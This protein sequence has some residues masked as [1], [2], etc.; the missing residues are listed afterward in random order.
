[1][2]G[3]ICDNRWRRRLTRAGRYCGVELKGVSRSG[4]LS[5]LIVL[6]LIGMT[7]SVCAQRN[8]PGKNASEPADDLQRMPSDRRIIQQLQ[9]LSRLA[10]AGDVAKIRDTLQ[11]LQAA[12]PSLMVADGSKTFRPLHRDLIERIQAFPPTLQLEL[13][14]HPGSTPGGLQIAWRDGG[15]PGLISFLHRCSG[16]TES[17]KAHLY[18]AAIHRDRGHGQAT[19][20]WLQPVLH[21]GAPADLRQIAVAMRDEVHAGIVKRSGAT[22]N[23]GSD[24]E[25][26]PGTADPSED[27]VTDPLNPETPDADANKVQA[28]NSEL[29]TESPETI[30]APDTAGADHT[31]VASFIFP[32]S[33]AWQRT[34]YLNST[35]RRVS[36]ELVRLLAKEGAE[37]AIAWIASEPEVDA[38]AVYVRS[39]GG[40]LALDRT[41]GQVLWTRLLD[42]SLAVRTADPVRRFPEGIDDSQLNLAQLLS[43]R[44]VV[45]LHR[46]EVTTGMTS[47]T[48]RLFVLCDTGE[49]A[50]TAADFNQPFGML[51]RRGDVVSRSLRELVAIEKST[52][53]RLWS[54]GGAPLEERFGNQL[55]RAWFAGPP[56]VSGGLLF[57][58]VERDDAHWLVC[59]RSETGEVVWKSMLAYPES[60]IFQ[61]PNR[62]LTASRPL[63]ADGMVWT[64]TNDGLLVAV[65]ALTHSVVWIRRMSRREAGVSPMRNFRNIPMPVEVQPFRDTW[66]PEAMRLISDSL[67]IEGTDSHQLQMIHPLTG[68]VRRSISPDTATVVLAADD[69]S[70]VVAGPGKIQRLRLEG[71][72]AVWAASLVATDVVPTGPGTR[73]NDHLWIPLSDGSI[74]I[75]RYSDGQLTDRIPA[76]R[77]A[78]SAGGLKSLNGD[79]VSYGPDHIS[80][81][82]QSEKA[83]SRQPDPL[84]QARLL[85][86]SGQLAAAEKV[87]NESSHNADQ[88]DSEQKLLFKLA[89]ARTL[90]DPTHSDEHLERAA[91]YAVTPQDHAI[92]HFLTVE[93]N[94]KITPDVVADFLKGS[95]AL[96]SSELPERE[97]L[98]QQLQRPMDD[99]AAAGDPAGGQSRFTTTR[100]LRKYLLQF[101]E[102]HLAD[103]DSSAA[104]PWLS[105]LEKIS[106]EDL[107]LMRLDASPLQNELLRRAEDSIKEGRLTECNWHLLMQARRCEDLIRSRTSEPSELSQTSGDFMQRLTS[108]V[109][110]FR[111]QLAAAVARKD[112]PL[113]PHRAASDLLDVVRA[114][115]LPSATEQAS[116]TPHELLT[117]KWSAWTDQTYSV[118]PVNPV[119]TNAIPQPNET[120]LL[121][122][123]RED[124]FLSAWL[125]ST[126]REPSVLALHSLIRPDEPL[127]TIEGGMFDAI[128]NSSSGSVMRLGSVVLVHNS[129]GLSAVSLVDQRV[130]WNRRI[131]NQSHRGLWPMIPAMRMFSSFSTAIEP[132]QHV[133]GRE[134]RICGGNDRWICLQSPSRI[135]MIDLLTGQNL[136]SLQIPAGP[137]HVFATESCVFLSQFWP[138]AS[139]N[140]SRSVTCLNRYDGTAQ[141]S[142]IPL[143]QLEQTICATGDELVTWGEASLGVSPGSLNW[144]NSV[145]GEVRRTLELNDMINCQF[146]D[147]RTLVSVTNKGTFEI[148]DLLTSEKQ[149]F[150]FDAE[151]NDGAETA[152]RTTPDHLARALILADAANYYV[153]PFPDQQAVQVQM[154]TGTMGE[155]QLFPLKDELRAIDRVTGKTRWVRDAKEDSAVWLEPTEN[156]LLLLVSFSPRRHKARPLPFPALGGIGFSNDRQ[157]TITAL[158]RITGTKLFDYNISSSSRFPVSDLKFSITS[159]QHLDLQAFGNRVRFV[160]EPAPPAVP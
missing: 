22:S 17:F 87:L 147:A 60:S 158:S 30:T 62:Q 110:Q 32:N 48:L 149:L 96:L 83:P 61:D 154:M 15:P 103:P 100:P 113:R 37:Q 58:M 59:L 20:Y 155:L 38:H 137:H 73:L 12:D 76:M 125:W 81:F 18:L 108:L 7:K 49:S 107:L 40:L 115:M 104:A 3:I 122:R 144:I 31:A 80:L 64:T 102:R 34:L 85:L 9:E 8:L 152:T 116:P 99:D 90:S 43:F 2:S 71:L 127:C 97:I 26:T 151:A 98:K 13:R 128:S 114:E 45:D 10:R 70:I 139:G 157:T 89:A 4:I 46:D 21:S 141:E 11:R 55:S 95:A 67:I 138:Q 86:Q 41:T 119:A 84:E 142:E 132:W 126:I 123:Y 47:D 92:V 88:F 36:Q 111:S 146:L 24:L 109:D 140:D 150:E 6:S 51:Q 134:L 130:L 79:V 66:R 160:P 121:P 19:L 54:V 112:L 53:R 42:R 50:G 23:S 159:Q 56:T 29:N 68:S 78:F 118:V 106:D 117:R 93:M 57:G 153:L 5:F 77:P 120:V 75:V 39:S 44:E 35:L 1:M 94:P 133:F 105:A 129:M 52:G 33:P 25:K 69:E 148:I 135:E 65:D 72:K 27:A 74:Q 131:P 101:F 14:K 136:W 145:T 16:S 143:S 63:V 91:R 124:R 82:S 156:P 28:E